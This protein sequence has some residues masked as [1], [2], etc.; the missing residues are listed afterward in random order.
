ME[1][2]AMTPREQQLMHAV[3][4][5]QGQMATLQNNVPA[6]APVFSHKAPKIPVP[7]KYSGPPKGDASAFLAQL[8]P[9]TVCGKGLHW[10]V[11]CPVVKAATSN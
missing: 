5:L 7:E 1:E 11:N 9:C 2:P 3:S 10:A 8:K 4:Q 6:P